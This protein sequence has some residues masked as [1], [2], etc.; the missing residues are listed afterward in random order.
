MLLTTGFLEVKSKNVIMAA[1]LKHYTPEIKIHTYIGQSPNVHTRR[2]SY[3]DDI[4]DVLVV[5][6]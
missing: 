3:T 6:M 4:N 2:T 5:V 1:S